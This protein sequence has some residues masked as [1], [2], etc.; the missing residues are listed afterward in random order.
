MTVDGTVQ[1]APDPNNFKFQINNYPTNRGDKIYMCNFYNDYK[2][3][4]IEISNKVS[5][6]I[7]DTTKEFNYTLAINKNIKYNAIKTDNNGNTTNMNVENGSTFTLKD[8][9]KL[10]IS[11]LTSDV[12]YSVTQDGT[13]YITR[14]NDSDTLSVTYTSEGLDRKINFVNTLEYNPLSGIDIDNSKFNLLSILILC[15]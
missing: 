7:G 15:T 4:N 2:K 5:G 13:N 9:E 6:T 12:T 8:K 14:V 11:N 10:T 3:E 1:D